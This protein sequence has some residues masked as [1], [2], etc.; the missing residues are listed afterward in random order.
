M[1]TPKT[2]FITGASSGFGAAFAKYALQMGY[3]VVATARNPER[4]SDLVAQAPKQVLALG[5]DVTRPQDAKAAVATAVQHFGRL[6]V[7]INNAGY[8]VLGA[9]EETPESE[10]RALMDTNFFGAVAV[11]EAALPVLRTQKSGSIVNISSLGGQ[12]SFAGFSAYSASKFALE[13]FSEALAQEVAGFGVKV[14]IVEPGNFRTNLL[15]SGTREMP[16][17]EDYRQAVGG[18]REFARNMHGAQLGDPMKAAAAIDRALAAD[19]TPLRLQLGADAIG[20]IRDH[21]NKLLQD[22][23][24]WAPVGSD[25]QIEGAIGSARPLTSR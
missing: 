9:A 21:A 11:I 3:N 23:E 16:A 24:Q 7:L 12:L 5:L 20:A 13:G 15:G 8:A 6:D 4:L 10:L 19:K 1:S 14:L 22:L 18:T 25:T 2:W 17:L